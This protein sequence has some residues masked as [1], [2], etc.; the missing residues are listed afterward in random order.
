MNLRKDEVVLPNG[1]VLPEFHVVEYPDWVSVLALTD[2]RQV[3][4]VEQYRHGVGEISLELPAGR[5]DKSENPAQAA[6]RELEEETGFKAGQLHLIG[7]CA[8]EPAK[9]SNYAHLYFADN[10]KRAGMPQPD[11]SEDIRVRLIPVAGLMN[12]IA[13]DRFIHGIHITAI[14]WAFQKGF[15]TD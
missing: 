5:I 11:E 14:L 12:A 10:V 6:A 3:V 9:H 8:P 7:K 15:L 1:V 2:D 4:L 13:D